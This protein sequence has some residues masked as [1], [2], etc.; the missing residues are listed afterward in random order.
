MLFLLEGSGRTRL[1]RDQQGRTLRPTTKGG[2]PAQRGV[3]VSAGR[4]RRLHSEAPGL[5]TPDSGTGTS[6]CVPLPRAQ[7]ASTQA[8]GLAGQAGA[9]TDPERYGPR[10]QG[11][12]CA[13]WGQGTAKGRWER[14]PGHSWPGPRVC[15]LRP[16]V[17]GRSVLSVPGS[18]LDVNLRLPHFTFCQTTASSAS[19]TQPSVRGFASALTVECRCSCAL[20]T[21]R[22]AAALPTF[23]RPG[24]ECALRCAA[25]R[26]SGPRC[27]KADCVLG[28]EGP[29]AHTRSSCGARTRGPAGVP[30]TGGHV[31]RRVP[32][33]TPRL[34]PGCSGTQ[35]P[36]P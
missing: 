18:W 19:Q 29:A 21:A 35:P 13:L 8:W 5:H 33:P 23:P 34:S 1:P 4:R 24:P 32:Q 9:R 22:T 27:G 2:V 12:H 3:Q 6:G 15:A 30:W 20:K 25:P 26:T 16:L 7:S 28:E 31:G 36:A 11:A 14:L 10:P 17:P